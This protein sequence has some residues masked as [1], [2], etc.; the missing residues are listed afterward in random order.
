V[1]IGQSF[2][3]SAWD[4]ANLYLGAVD[5]EPLSHDALPL[6]GLSEDQTCY[7]SPAYFREPDPFADFVVH[8]VAHI[9][10]NTRRQ[11]AGLPETRRKYLLDI[12]Y[13]KRETFAYACEAYSRVLQRAREP[14]R[15]R[16]LAQEFRGFGVTDDRVAPAEVVDIVR[17]A[18]GHR[19]GW[20][21]ILTR[22]AA[23]AAARR[24]RLPA[25]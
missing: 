3:H 7:V 1:L 13:S 17:A 11:T 4:I 14:A 12:H 22:C 24:D 6:L 23:P 10:H 2:L 8:E 21:L 15:R 9:F 20:K 16:A 19:N 5:A 18:C 25:I